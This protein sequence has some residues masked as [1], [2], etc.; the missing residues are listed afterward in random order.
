VEATH[1]SSGC[2]ENGH[3][4]VAHELQDVSANHQPHFVIFAIFKTAREGLKTL[5]PEA[6]TCDLCLKRERQ[7]ATSSEFGLKPSLQT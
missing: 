4:L 2:D 3:K 7:T 5:M 1:R 6:S